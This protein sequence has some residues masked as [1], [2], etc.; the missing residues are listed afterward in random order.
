MKEKTKS[1]ILLFFICL[2]LV[3]GFI[4]GA[5]SKRTMPIQVVTQEKVLSGI[6]VFPKD[7]KLPMDTDEKQMREKIK[8]T[9]FY[10]G[11]NPSE[12]IKD[13]TTD[14]LKLQKKE[15]TKKV[16]ITYTLNNCTKKAKLCITFIPSQQLKPQLQ[17]PSPM[18]SNNP[19]EEEDINFPYISGYPDK[20]FRPNQAVTRE[21][22]A[23]M[24]A[25]LI[26][27][28]Q[29]PTEINH[30]KDLSEKRFSTDAINYI[31]KLGIM[32][33]VSQDTFDPLGKV[34]DKQFQEIINNAKPYIKDKQVPLPQ[35]MGDLTREEAVVALNRLFK[36]QC[37]TA[38]ISSPF[39]D[40]TEASP[41]YKAILCA[42]QPRIEPR[43]K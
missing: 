34:T 43:K 21:E 37:S 41:N 20:T 2:V 1:I 32:K 16:T 18:P 22:L 10:K 27:K 19:V 31:T 3:P 35:G 24:L 6:T 25:R 9:A 4:V 29:I 15:G 17:Q 12:E 38:Y 8:V 30:Y 40:V 28:N 42:T 7:L 13:Y 23:T 5:S 14:F 26:T 36:V 11:G 39:T 33:P